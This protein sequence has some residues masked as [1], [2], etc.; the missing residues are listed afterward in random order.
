MSF[1]PESAIILQFAIAT[2]VIAV[3]PGPDMTLFVGRA[4][5]QGRAAGFACML[6]AMT[7]IVVHTTMVSLGLSALVVAS[8]TAFWALKCV[9]AAYLVW[10]AVRALRHG[11][12]F[13]PDIRATRGSG[14][15]ANWA[16]GLGI[17]LLNPKIILFFMTFLPQFVSASDPNAAEKL[18]FLGLLFIPLSLPVT[19]PMVLAADRFAGLLRRSPRVTR[20][21]DYLFAG[22]FSAF[23]I[24]ILATEAR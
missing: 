6:G 19:V 15:A 12:A 22:V 1:V 3:T 13:S 10:L 16:T 18:F 4:L 17:N 7:G 8:P 20:V 23:A 11:S 24:R 5:A 21:I 9:G 14:L 2:F